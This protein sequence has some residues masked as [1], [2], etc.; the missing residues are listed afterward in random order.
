MQRLAALLS[1]NICTVLM[2]LLLI[3]LSLPAA[4]AQ[5]MPV[6]QTNSSQADWHNQHEP[7]STAAVDCE[8][9]CT[10]TVH[11][12]C[13]YALISNQPLTIFRPN[14]AHSNLLPY[15]F[16]SRDITPLTQPPK[17]TSS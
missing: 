11:H 6:A 1:A 2:L 4:F 10:G 13:L 12:C 8:A 5:P 16:S 14:T 17:T 3:F 9:D 7:S 15:F